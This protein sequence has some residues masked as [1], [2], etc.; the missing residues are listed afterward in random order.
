MN[1]HQM[2]STK[3]IQKYLRRE[4]EKHKAIN[5]TLIHFQ[6]T[7]EKPIN[8]QN[9]NLQ[10]RGSKNRRPMKKWLYQK[11]TFVEIRKLTEL[12]FAES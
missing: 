8:Q 4:E 11:L 1:W 6:T 10:Q 7:T 2:K 12:I 9:L 3:G 5:F